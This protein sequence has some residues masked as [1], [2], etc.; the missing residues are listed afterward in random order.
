MSQ[1]RPLL[2]KMGEQSEQLQATYEQH[3][4][5]IYQFIYSRVGNREDAED[6]TSQVFVKA[7]RL[8]ETERSEMSIRSWLFRVARTTIA[9]YWRE[10]YRLPSVPLDFVSR[11][12]TLRSSSD[13]PDEEELDS[14]LDESMFE[15]AD[16]HDAANSKVNPMVER[17]LAALPENY[18]R[19]LTLRFL[20][21]YSIRE[22]AAEM[23]ISESN[24]KVMQYR[25]LQKAAMIFRLE[26]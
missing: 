4:S 25:A 17:I 20:H 18:R 5:P 23:G 24:A 22:A 13:S 19:I 3:V 15:P 14:T 7:L 11:A 21:G 2:R 6:L 1:S 8:L 9:D 10:R 16:W 26:E 12:K